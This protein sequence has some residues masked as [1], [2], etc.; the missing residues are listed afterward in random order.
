V[1]IMVLNRVSKKHVPREITGMA[2]SPH[3]SVARFLVRLH[4]SPAVTNITVICVA[5]SGGEGN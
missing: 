4:M 5:M 3:V 1:L 2:S